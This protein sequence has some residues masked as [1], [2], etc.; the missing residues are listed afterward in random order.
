MSYFNPD[1]LKVNNTANP[2]E[3]VTD[4]NTIFTKLLV[5]IFGYTMAK[6]SV[7]SVSGMAGGGFV[8]GCVEESLTHVFPSAVYL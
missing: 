2:R 3:K 6:S 5:L 7:Q 8:L 1:L 4:N